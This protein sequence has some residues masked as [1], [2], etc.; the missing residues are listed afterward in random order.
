M[1]LKRKEEEPF[2][3][4]Q[5][6]RKLSQ[7]VEKQK[8]KGRLFWD[9]KKL[10]TYEKSQEEKDKKIRPGLKRRYALWSKITRV[11]TDRA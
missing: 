5:L 1:T 9:S 11:R 7:F 10:G 6:K 8:L 2:E 3:E 4:Y